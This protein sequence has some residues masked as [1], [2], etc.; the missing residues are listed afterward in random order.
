MAA[1]GSIIITADV[2]AKKAQAEL[3]RLEKDIEKFNQRIEE[4]K[5]AQAPLIANAEELRLK[6][7]EATAEAKRYEQEW[8]QGNIVADHNQS[9][10][11]QRVAALRQEYDGV[12]EKIEKYDEK[13]AGTTRQ[14]DSAKERAGEL[15]TQLSGVGDAGAD[16]GNKAAAAIQKF[17]KRV[18]G[19]I[20][21]VFIFSI[22]TMALRNIRSWLSKVIKTNDE[23]AAALAK[24]KAAFLTLAQP[25]IEVVLPI[26]TAFLN[27]LANIVGYISAFVS[28]LFGKS[29]EESANAAE[30]L[31]EEKKELSGVGKAANKAKREL[32]GFD[33]INKLVGDGLGAGFDDATKATAPDFDF[34]KNIN[35]PKWL[36]DFLGDFT[37]TFKDIFFNWDNLTGE[38]IAKK[39]ISGLSALAGAVVGFSL[40]GVPGAIVG[41][42]AG[43][44]LS[45][46]FSTLLFDNDGQL[47]RKEILKMLVAAITAITGG[48]LGAPIGGPFGAGLGFLIGGALGITLTKLIFSSDKEISKKEVLRMIF[49]A[50][51][52][53]IG[54]VVGF[55]LGG[56][57]GA[58]IGIIVGARITLR[59][60]NVLIDDDGKFKMSGEEV[61][62]WFM[63]GIE[64]K[65]RDW[66][67]WVKEHIWQPLWEAFSAAF[68]SETHKKEIGEMGANVTDGLL[69]G[70]SF[71]SNPG[72]YLG[73]RVLR[74]VVLPIYDAIKEG[75]EISSPSKL[76]QTLGGY[77]SE[78]LID[79]ISIGIEDKIQVV[80]D[81]LNSIIDVVERAVNYIVDKLNSIS[82]TAPDWVPFVGGKHFGF[83][84]PRV[85]IPRLAEGGVIPPN[86]EFLA[87]LGDQ[88]SGTNIEA[89]LDTIVAA[90]RQVMSEQGNGGGRTIVLQLD[91]RELGKAVVDVYNLESQ[92]V[93]LKLGGAY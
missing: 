28:K 90:F 14:L 88:K 75:F 65:I 91:R 62:K 7:A 47:S 60:A 18:V 15:A 8:T 9:D 56:P 68:L 1:D 58:A 50:L 92:R 63:D 82:F 41:A 61:I 86:R 5:A 29:A 39:I 93:G 6:I 19:L 81:A 4:N 36:D 35:L 26:L 11:L 43:A 66:R 12:L 40:G 51:G 46:A 45:V 54:G 83:S 52:A 85:S 64:G 84:I 34:V 31:N 2:D 87:V 73:W 59:I 69:T 21:R 78:G 27:T 76:M 24:L 42:L 33:E 32:A 70:M 25:I 49:A 13:I 79:G 77:I 20:K 30:S 37:I 44:L 71:L 48:I 57:A 23:A 72:F 10:A 74:N 67:V 22:I 89:P 16:A 3:K 38:G 53:I 80:K 17:E 55:S